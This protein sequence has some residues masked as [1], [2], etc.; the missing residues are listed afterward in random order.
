MVEIQSSDCGFHRAHEVR[1]NEA[2]RRL[3]QVEAKH[4]DL[5]KEQDA[6]KSKSEDTHD[7]IDREITKTK[8]ELQRRIGE[9]MPTRHALTL[10]SVVAT[11]VIALFALNYNATLQMTAAFQESTRATVE[12]L[13]LLNERM[14]KVE[15]ILDERNRQVKFQ[16][17]LKQDLK[18][19][20]R[21]LHGADP[22]DNFLQ[23][24]GNR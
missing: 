24:G 15:T 10:A 16:Q 17:E 14:V 20:M 23:D 21:S 3:N 13:A 6:M 12:A 4:T 18:D 19:Y 11:A 5:R 9:K 7:S 2:E 8:D 22:N 1:L